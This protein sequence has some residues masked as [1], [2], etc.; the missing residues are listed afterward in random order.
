M[1]PDFFTQR[2]P[3]A[4]LTY[5]AYFELLERTARDADSVTGDDEAIERAAATKLNLHRSKRI[6]KTYRISD[7][8]ARALATIETPQLWM[9]LTEPWC[10]DSAQCLPHIAKMAAGNPKIDLRILLRDQNLDVMDLYLTN[11][12]RAIPRLVAFAETGAEIFQWGPRPA[13]AAA[14]HREAQAAG[15]EKP[16]LLEK[17]HLWYGR[18]RGVAIDGE[19]VKTLI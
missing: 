12:G 6:G 19:F 3:H 16:A 1:V 13:E 5:D 18:N 2:R 17:L 4:G 15:L 7:E 11:G 8:L 14:I 9:V 10:G